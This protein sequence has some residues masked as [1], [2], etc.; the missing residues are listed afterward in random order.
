MKKK[1]IFFY[2]KKRSK[3]LEMNEKPGPVFKRD[4]E[5]YTHICIN[6]V[7]CFCE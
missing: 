3:T 2:D 4:Q 7:I 5:N 6:I 1:I